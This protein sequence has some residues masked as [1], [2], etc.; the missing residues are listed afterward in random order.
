MS[1]GPGILYG[2]EISKSIGLYGYFPLLEDYE[3]WRRVLVV[4]NK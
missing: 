2:K 4:C 1:D 3:L